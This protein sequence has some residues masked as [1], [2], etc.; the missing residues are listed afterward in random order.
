[1]ELSHSMSSAHGVLD[2]CP[3]Q[4]RLSAYHDGELD[5]ATAAQ[6]EAHLPACDACRAELEEIAE[7]SALANQIGA[8]GISQSA[9]KNIHRSLDAEQRLSIL[10]VAGVLTALA[11]SV[12]IVGLVWLREIPTSHSMPSQIVVP[13]RDSQA[14]EN[15]A[16]NFQVDPLPHDRWEVRDPQGLADARVVD[17]MLRGLNGTGHE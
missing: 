17:W 15:V 10:R 9:L 12:L 3:F 7:L 1:M 4:S 11:A 5:A 13:T 16:L 6:V 14:W 2:G 8:E